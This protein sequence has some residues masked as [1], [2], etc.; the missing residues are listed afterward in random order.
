MAFVL[1]II[2][3]AVSYSAGR[4]S[5]VSGLATVIG[6]GY[7]YGIV[8]ANVP[9][10]ASH[11]IFDA[12]V[13]GLY[14]AQLFR[15]LDA[16]QQYRVGSLK[17]WVEALV[18]LGL[19]MFLVPFQDMVVQAVGLRGAIFFLPFLLLGARMSDDE[20]YELALWLA[21]LN[22]F[23]LLVASAEFVIGVERFFP[24]NEVTAIIYIS[25][26]VAGYKAYRIPST[27]AN[28]HAYGGTMV[29][30]LPFILGALVQRHKADWHKQLLVAALSASILGVLLCAARSPFLLLCVVLVVAL[31]SVKGKFGYAFGLIGIACFIG[32][33]VSGEARLQRFTQ[34]QDTTMVSQRFKGSVNMTF[35]DVAYQYPFGNG[36]GGGGTSLP[37]FLLDRVE[38]PV[39]IENEYAR[40]MLEQGILGLLLWIAFI[41]WVLSRRPFKHDLWNSGWR[42]AW[43]ASAVYF[44]VSVTGTGLLTAI[45]QTG[46]FLLIVGWVGAR[47][48]AALGMK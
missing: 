26:D 24:R 22:V 35:V 10:A 6:I 44:A 20:R 11:F 38:N 13:V 5:L 17:A 19:V 29:I 7:V 12:A 3:L 41:L 37:Y 47:Q 33:M 32:W 18:A 1:C 15:R 8:R 23:A 2:A 45:P 28:A 21:A 14:A 31:F 42:L 27:F 16:E 48:P 30:T 46:L 39:V 4:R 34:L 40:I 9:S 43:T 25:R 36:L